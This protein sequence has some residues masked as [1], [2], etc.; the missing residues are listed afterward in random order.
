MKIMI[1]EDDPVAS[2][3]L[4]LTLEQIGHEVIVFSNGADA[5]ERF[6]EEPVRIVVSDWMMPK[7]DGLQ[8]CRRIR[9]RAEREQKGEREYTYFILLTANHAGRD[10]LALAMEAGIDDFLQ[11][12]L[13]REGIWMR[14]RVAERILGFS[15]Q[16]R[17]LAELL[18]ICSYCKK[19]RDDS[20][21]WQQF[22]A[23]IQEN[24]GSHFS[25]GICPDCFEEQMHDLETKKFRS[26]FS[27]MPG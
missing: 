26:T 21:Y 15:R 19:I 1:A 23:Y 11:K 14:L 16:I 27:V 7:L 20:A 22:E 2:K 9:E 3:I 10:N 18:P 25:H 4:S 13:D 8:L 17:Q 24:T 12:P 6:K 5:W